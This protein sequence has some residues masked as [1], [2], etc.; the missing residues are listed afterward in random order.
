LKSTSASLFACEGLSTGGGCRLLLLLLLLLEVL[1][2][3]QGAKQ[4]WGGSGSYFY[5]E[6]KV[7]WVR[8]G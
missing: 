1:K 7:T 6:G 2:D 4:D 8:G 3:L 5:A